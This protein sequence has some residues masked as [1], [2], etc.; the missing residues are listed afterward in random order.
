MWPRSGVARLR[1]AGAIGQGRVGRVVLLM[2]GEELPDQAKM[3][4]DGEGIERFE[5]T[6][7]HQVKMSLDL[8]GIA[9][10]QFRNN[11]LPLRLVFTPVGNVP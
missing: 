5:V 8:V 7:G 9:V 2:I 1:M 6:L 3:L 11:R 10:V 4:G